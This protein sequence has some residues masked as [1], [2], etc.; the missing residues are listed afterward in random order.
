MTLTDLASIGGFVS[1]LAVTV[2]LI[3]LLL[4]MRQTERIQHGV[5]QQGRAART[6]DFILRATDPAL[7]ETMVR[8]N[9]SDL[10][11]AVQI[12]A[13]NTYAVALF[14]S[15][16]DSFLQQQKGLLDAASWAT[17]VATLKGFFLTPAWRVAWE[18]TRQQAGEEFRE[19]VDSVLRSMKPVKAYDESSIWKRLMEK[20]L[21][22]IE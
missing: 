7:C 18:M 6:V 1:G 14:W 10:L 22:E 5:I 12:S 13:L 17:E 15:I 21:A 11:T 3:L 8:A 2:T 9:K 4:Q 16:E 20:Q 19:Y